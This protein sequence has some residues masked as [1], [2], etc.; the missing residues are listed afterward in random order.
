[1]SKKKK[2]N[3]T[4]GG[5]HKYLKKCIFTRETAFEYYVIQIP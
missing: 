2:V 3:M 4:A 1:V 5:H